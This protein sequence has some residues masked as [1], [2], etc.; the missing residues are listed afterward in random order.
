MRPLAWDMQLRLSSAGYFTCMYTCIYAYINP[1]LVEADLGER[2]FN[3][4]GGGADEVGYVG[5]GVVFRG[6]KDM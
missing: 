2:G 3:G 1:Q 4:G 6:G 5:R